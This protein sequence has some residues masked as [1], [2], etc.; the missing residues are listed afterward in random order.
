MSYSSCYK[1]KEMVPYYDKYCPQCRKK[2][3]LPDLPEY[4]KG[5]VWP[6]DAAR[7]REYRQDKE[8]QCQ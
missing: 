1:C 6:D 2:W 3:R 7:L 5:R 8:T 4:Q